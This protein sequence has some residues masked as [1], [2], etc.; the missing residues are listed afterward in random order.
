MST[1]PPDR[2]AVVILNWN[3][4]ELT[5]RC[6]DIAQA[7]TDL[8]AHWIVVDN[9]SKEPLGALP[10]DV[11]VIRNAENLGFAGGVNVGLKHAFDRGADYV[12]L[13]NNDAEALP[14]ALDRLVA[15]MRQDAAIGQ[16][17]SLI[18]NADEN[19]EIECYGGYT[20]HGTS[21]TTKSA[22]QY[23]EWRRQSPE[24]IFLLGTSLLVRRA[25]VEK[26]GYFDAGLFAYHEDND[27]SRRTAAG[28]FS[29]V[30]VAESQVRH[31]S[32]KHDDR[33]SRPP[34]YYYYMVRNE[35]LVMRK[36][37]DPA[38]AIYWAL[39][40]HWRWY[41]N[42]DVPAACHRAIRLGML[43]GLLGRTGPM[44]SR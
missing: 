27:F 5:R 14:H 20:H 23:G 38:K 25:L 21:L 3:K 32:G 6:V 2:V 26:I 7:A 34:Y 11:S 30:V 35:L 1:L 36:L 19:D 22:E 17:S 10:A 44:P 24:R 8:P 4:A 33:V 16:A 28:G 12:W 29:S 9:A 39:R 42:Q 15:A 40:R 41:R 31:A 37:G 18:L 13:L 43:H